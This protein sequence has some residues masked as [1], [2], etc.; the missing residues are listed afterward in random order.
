MCA[1]GAP[2]SFSRYTL[3]TDFL[4]CIVHGLRLLYGTY[5]ERDVLSKGHVSRNRQVVQ[6]QHVRDALE[7]GQI[8]LNLNT[9]THHVNTDT[10]PGT[11]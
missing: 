7:T 1:L 9:H 8:L 3:W 10:W 4:S 5:L 6:L 2:R 11:I